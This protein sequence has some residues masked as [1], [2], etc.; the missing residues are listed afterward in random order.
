MGVTITHAAALTIEELLDVS[1]GAEIELGDDVRATIAGSRA[2]ID[3]MLEGDE[4]VYGLNTGVGHMKDSRVPVAELDGLSEL[5]FQLGMV[6]HESFWAAESEVNRSIM[7]DRRVNRLSHGVFV[8][9]DTDDESR[10]G[11]R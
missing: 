2:V 9:R 1:V 11:A 5:K 10:Q 7:R 4:P 3:R 8:R 6:D